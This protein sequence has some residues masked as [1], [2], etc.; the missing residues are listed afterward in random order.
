MK[1]FRLSAEAA[2]DIT[3]IYNHIAEESVDTAG[4]VI[5]RIEQELWMLAARP[6]IGHKRSDLTALDPR[7]DHAF[8]ADSS[9]TMLDRNALA[10][11]K[12]ISVL[13]M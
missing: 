7:A 10:S 2:S 13:S 6:G 5:T 4:R 1:P 3:E 8:T 9:F 12:S 11:P